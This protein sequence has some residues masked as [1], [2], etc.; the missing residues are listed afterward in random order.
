MQTDFTRW[1][2]LYR[3]TP[4]CDVPRHFAG[5]RASPFMLRYL[6]S[7]LE[8]TPPGGRTLETGI[9]SGNGAIWLSLRGIC[10]EGLDIAERNVERAKYVNNMLGGSAA[11]RVGDLFDLYT[12][13]VE[14]YSV[15][16]HQGV[17]EHFCHIGKREKGKGKREEY[18]AI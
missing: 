9:G 7:I 11:F 18:N 6:T 2:H 13:P 14:R 10:A 8:R 16:H 5:I 15:V 4:L 17:L 12:E 1:E 3:Q